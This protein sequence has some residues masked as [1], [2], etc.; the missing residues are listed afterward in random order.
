MITTVAGKPCGRWVQTANGNIAKWL[1][2]CMRAL[3]NAASAPGWRGSRCLKEEGKAGLEKQSKT[4]YMKQ[5]E[6]KPPPLFM[7]NRACDFLNEGQS[8]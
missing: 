3:P 6:G 5:V 1:S 4:S 2:S 7:I 8:E